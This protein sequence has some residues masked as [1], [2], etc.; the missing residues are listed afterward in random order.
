MLMMLI[1]IFQYQRCPHVISDYSRKMDALDALEIWS[2]LEIKDKSYWYQVTQEEAVWADKF[3][4]KYP[5]PIVGIQLKSSTWVRTWPPE[6]VIRLIRMLRYNG[7]TVVVIDNHSFGFKDEGVVNLASGYDIREIASIVSKLALLITP[8]SGILH[9]GAHFKIPTVAL[10][11]G[12]DPSCRLKYYS[13]VHSICKRKAV[14]EQWP[15][16]SHAYIC[17]KGITPS[18]CMSAIKAEE[19][20]AI[21]KEI[22]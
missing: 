20:F 19:V 4:N 17:P 8:D 15:C 9:F 1:I 3:L 21:V 22:L 2:G 10:F 13:T 18:P 7:I 5:R 16:W 14:C 11:G 6:E 12:S